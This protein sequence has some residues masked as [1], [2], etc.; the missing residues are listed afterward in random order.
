MGARR[1]I[2][3]T[4]EL[5]T[6][7]ALLSLVALLRLYHI[8]ADPPNGLSVST[9]VETDPPQY[10]IFAR[11]YVQNGVFDPFHDARRSVFLKS[12]V[13]ALAVGVFGLLGTGL[14]QSNLVGFLYGFGALVLFW[15]F[16]RKVSGPVAGL[17]FLILISVNYNLVFFGRLPFL[18]H[19]LAFWA[20][21]SLALLAHV[22]R[23]MHAIWAGLA[24]AVG[25]FFGK[26][27]G[28]IFLFPF[29]CWFGYRLLFA[30]KGKRRERW[31]QPLFFA[32]G[33]AVVTVFWL[34]FTYLPAQ[35]Q[36]TGYFGEQ[37][38]S[39]YGAPE[40]LQSVDE[41]MRKLVT[42]GIDSRLLTRMRSVAV[43]GAFFVGMIAFHITRKKS[44]LE[45]FGRFN[46]GHV[47][48]ATMIVA[49][50]GSL[51]I[52]NYRPLRYQ[53]V[54]IYPFYGAA[55]TLLALIWERW[56]E[57]KPIRTPWGFYPLAV[58]IAV[59]PVYQFWEALADRYG[60]EFYYDDNKL[61]ALGVALVLVILIG[62]VL[63]YRD[64]LSRPEYPPLARAGVVILIVV[65]LT[66][67]VLNYYYWAVRPTFTARDDSRDL[68][69][70]LASPGAV[71][72]GPF[73]PL[74]AME[75]RLPVVIQ[76]F[77][78]AQVDT[79][80]FRRFP[81]THLLVDESNENAARAD[82]PGLLDSAEHVVTY[83]VGL[84]KVRLF[85]I[86]GETG[87]TQ[88]SAYEESPVE[89]MIDLYQTD[90]I[91]R[92][93][94]L[95]ARLL[96]E[97]PANMSIYLAVAEVAALNTQLQLAETSFKKAVEFSPTNYHLNSRLAQFFKETYAA[98]GNEAYKKQGL[99]YFERAIHLAPTVRNMEA[100]YQQLKD[101]SAWQ[102]KSDTT[103][104][105]QP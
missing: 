81:I 40:G 51:M 13:T 19:A 60:L 99:D 65:N 1:P 4:L 41:F 17:L 105:S 74:L 50:Y 73:A 23:P 97:Y 83:H 102:L 93:N 101:K 3:F 12:S 82:Y 36:V 43:V 77:G 53:L 91:S 54:L 26:V 2:N 58:L 84:K 80:L 8:D 15:L 48:M 57:P 47:F 20:F 25:I 46:A 71:I 34:F 5:I 11:N 61:P 9:G 38:V 33:F 72:S 103:S 69:I 95:A 35:S 90:Q 22:D 30:P 75:N 67:G 27:L 52:W 96:Q 76:M 37:A 79:S 78:V 89:R 70:V 18:E 64:R 16:L 29:A 28:L 94:E 39:L 10:T 98:T 63:R 32:G 88:A 62:L 92:G 86:A 56:G 45:G 85:R 55:A 66:F 104:L 59:V 100:A 68:G 49:F 6:V 87:N 14:W 44:W 42:F 24:L 31:L 7:A 21:L